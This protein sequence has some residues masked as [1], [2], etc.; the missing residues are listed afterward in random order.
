MVKVCLSV[1]YIF[2]MGH[3]VV[4]CVGVTQLVSGFLSEATALSGARCL[5]SAWEGEIQELPMLPSYP[6][7][8]ALTLDLIQAGIIY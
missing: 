1:S 3:L 4:W 5:V 2:G 6:R 8:T 7:V